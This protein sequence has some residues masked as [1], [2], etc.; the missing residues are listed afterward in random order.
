VLAKEFP[1][2]YATMKNA[3]KSQL[4]N[5]IAHSTY[6]IHGRYIHLNNYIKEDPASQINVVPF[7]EWIDIFHDTLVFYSQIARIMAMVDD[8][9]NHIVKQTFE[10]VEIRINRL[11][12]VPSVA[13]HLLKHRPGINQ[14]YWAGWWIK[15]GATTL[16]ENWPVNAGSD[17][18]LN[19]IMFG[20]IGAWFYKGLGGILPDTAAPGFK[21]IIL[22]PHIIPGLDSFTAAHQSPYGWI[23]SGWKHENGHLIYI[24]TIPTG[25][26]ATLVMEG[27]YKLNRRL[28]SGTYH[29]RLE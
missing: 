13:Y 24:C 19:H 15:N 8:F 26:S 18:S 10:T 29:F 22:R 17:A 25:S 20:E 28:P 11:D 6:S 4:R 14:W 7:D 27:E 21:H 2:I 1:L 5:S 16:Y 9:F 3:Y 12:P 23:R